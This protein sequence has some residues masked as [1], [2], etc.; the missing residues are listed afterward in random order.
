M[1]NLQKNTFIIPIPSK[2]AKMQYLIEDNNVMVL[3]EN[4][5]LYYKCNFRI[6]KSLAT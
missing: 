3:V 2:V 1:R 4:I 6:K 5:A